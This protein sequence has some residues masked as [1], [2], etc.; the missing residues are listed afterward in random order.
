[1]C[2]EKYK[3][4]TERTQIKTFQDT[5]ISTMQRKTINQ[6]SNM[7]KNNKQQYTE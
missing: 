7:I 1:M 5:Q 4:K 6:Y 3:K 2:T